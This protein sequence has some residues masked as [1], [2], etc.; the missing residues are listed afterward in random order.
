MRQL[1]IRESLDL[2]GHLLRQ[3]RQQE[4][5]DQARGNARHAVSR[6]FPQNEASPGVCALLE[7]AMTRVERCREADTDQR[8]DEMPQPM[9]RGTLEMGVHESVEHLPQRRGAFDLSPEGRTDERGRPLHEF[10]EESGAWVPI[11]YPDQG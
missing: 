5:Q 3:Q 6:M 2:Q 11:F 4:K 9:T 8:G 1:S 10:D 7:D